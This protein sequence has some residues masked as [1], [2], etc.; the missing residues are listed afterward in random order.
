MDR[1]RIKQALIYV[2]QEAKKKREAEIQRA[3]DAAAKAACEPE[4]MKAATVTVTSFTMT[5]PE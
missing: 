1:K 5:D 2:T 4:A 3:M